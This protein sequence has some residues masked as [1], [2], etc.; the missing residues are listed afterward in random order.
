MKKVCVCVVTWVPAAIATSGQFTK[1]NKYYFATL[2]MGSYTASRS[3]ESTDFG[4]GLVAKMLL[5]G[6]T[7]AS[8]KGIKQMIP[9]S[10]PKKQQFTTQE[11]LVK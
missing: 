11:A 10:S 1:T 9:S 3:M 6:S 8:N 2:S 5:M 7:S 4:L